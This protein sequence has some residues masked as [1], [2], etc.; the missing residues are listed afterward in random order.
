MSAGF[1]P[2]MREA[3]AMST[4]CTRASFSRDSMDSVEMAMKSTSF[5]IVWDALLATFS[6][7]LVCRRMKPAY[8]ISISAHCR[9]SLLSEGGPPCPCASST[10]YVTCGLRRRS[11]SVG[12]WE[13][14]WPDAR[15]AALATSL[16]TLTRTEASRSFSPEMAACLSWK[17]AHRRSSISPS[18][19]PIGVSRASALSDRSSSRYSLREVSMRYGSRRSLVMRSSIRV[20]R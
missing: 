9:S 11:S 8:L 2:P 13:M 4:G 6:S 20:P 17:S 10:S 1:T 3:C 16:S 12:A 18:S 14:F 5:G 19:R 7:C 15:A